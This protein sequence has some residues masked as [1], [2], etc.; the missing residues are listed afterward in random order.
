[1]DVVGGRPSLAVV[2][3][4]S[5]IEQQAAMLGPRSR[6]W[7]GRRCPSGWPSSTRSTS[8]T[9]PAA[10]DRPLRPDDGVAN[11]FG[12]GGYRRPL[13]DARAAGVRFASECLALA[14]VGPDGVADGAMRDV[15]SPWDFLDVT[16]HYLTELYGAEAGDELLPWVSGDVM[17][18][19]LGEWRRAGSPCA[20]AFV[21]WL[22]DLAP[23]AGWGLLDSTGA[24]KAVLAALPAVL[25]PVA[26]WTTDE[27]LGGLA[28][29]VA[30]DRS[31][32][33]RADLRVTL[34][35]DG[36][37]VV[38]EGTSPVTVPARGC[39]TGDVETLL[40]R[41][42]DAAYAYRFGPPQHDLVVAAIDALDLSYAREPA[43]RS[44]ARSSAADLGLAVTGGVATTRRAVLG[45]R[46]G[47]GPQFCIEPGRERR[48]RGAGPLTARNLVGAV[49][50]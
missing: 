32:P 23:G 15:D 16:R 39:F 2:C 43:G 29:H 12:V 6:R 24:P 35:R 48:L 42:V 31:E 5:E 50:P 46:V 1:M 40:G 17:A 37:H 19:T 41:W 27:G 30:N 8:P 20:G 33:L 49:A 47:D 11:Y 21:L 25:A 3:G 22:R 14:N 10:P 9:R 44:A 36:E 18:E 45:A 38:A 28:V 7:R 34:Y 13:S 26:V 4:G